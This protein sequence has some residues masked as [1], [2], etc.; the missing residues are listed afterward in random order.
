M[1]RLCF[2]TESNYFKPPGS[3]I[4]SPDYHREYFRTRPLRFDCAVVYDESTESYHEFNNTQAFELLGMLA[5]A[6]TLVS[7]SGKR[8]DLIVLEHAC[9]EDRIKPLWQIP[10]HDLFEMCQWSSLDDLTH[11]YASNIDLQSQLDYKARIAQADLLKPPADFIPSKLAKAR[12]DV[13]RTFAVF[14]AINKRP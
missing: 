14:H 8:V 3:G 1:K 6:T 4:G 12:Y 9:G 10:H 11:K 5:S 7:H 13:E 2:D